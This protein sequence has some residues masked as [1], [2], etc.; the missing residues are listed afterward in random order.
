VINPWSSNFIVTSLYYHVAKDII[1]L[2]HKLMLPIFIFLAKINPYLI[3][4]FILTL[5]ATG[6]FL[7]YTSS[8]L[9]PVLQALA[10]AMASYDSWY[11]LPQNSGRL[12]KFLASAINGSDYVMFPNRRGM[13]FA[14]LTQDCDVQFTKAFW[15]INQDPNIRVMWFVLYLSVWSC[16]WVLYYIFQYDLVFECCTVSFSMILCLSVVLYLSVWSCVW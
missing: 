6:W 7:Q 1:N 8:Y 11:Q 10:I 3:L 12:V 14:D 2:T 15:S 9:R 16:V 5:F 13:K 4:N